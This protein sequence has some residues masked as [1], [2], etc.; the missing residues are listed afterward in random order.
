MNGFLEF[1]D[2]LRE[3]QS[4]F[5]L[6]IKELLSHMDMKKL[7]KNIAAMAIGIFLSRCGIMDTIYPFGQGYFICML[8]YSSYYKAA[9]LGCFIGWLSLFP[10]VPFSAMLVC[11]G[12]MGALT[13]ANSRFKVERSRLLKSAYLLF[14]LLGVLL[15]NMNGRFFAMVGIS[16]AVISVVSLFIYDKTAKA[17][18]VHKKRS[19]LTDDE[20]ICLVF[21]LCTLVIFTGG[22]K[23]GTLEVNIILAGL[24]TLTFGYIFGSTVGAATGVLCGLCVSLG[25][26]SVYTMGSMGV[27]GFFAGTAKG[28]GRIGSVIAYGAA[29]SLLTIYV[30][31]SSF[32]ILPIGCTLVSGLVLVLMPKKVMEQLKELLCNTLNRSREERYYVEKYNSLA[33]EK[34]DNL[35]G[36]FRTMAQMFCESSRPRNRPDAHIS[37]IIK[38][39]ADECCKE[40]VWHKKCW[41]EDF[42]ATYS[43]FER[44]TEDVM[45]AREPAK[46][47][48]RECINEIGVIGAIKR[49]EKNAREERRSLQRSNE[50]KDLLGKQFQGVAGLLMGMHG[51]IKNDVRFESDIE[52]NIRDE[53]TLFNVMVYD[54]CVM[55]VAGAYRC[56]VSVKGCGGSL[57]CRH[58]I[59]KTVSKFCGRPMVLC[60]TL[61]HGKKNQRCRLLYIAAKPLKVNTFMSQ[62]S[63]ESVCGDSYKVGFISDNRYM[64]CISDGM[65][66]GKSAHDESNA[67]IKLLSGFFKAGFDDSVV[68]ATVNK[69]LMLKSDTEI[70]TT[71]DLCMVDTVRSRAVFTKIGA[72]PSVLIKEEGERAVIKGDSLPLGI[73]EEVNEKSFEIDIE[74]G[75]ILV[76][77]TDG[78]YDA[79]TGKDADIE[80][81][82]G[83]IAGSNK[84]IRDITSAII[85]K[86]KEETDV[87]NRDDMTI[88]VS[89]FKKEKNCL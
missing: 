36:L 43:A 77:F 50:G 32:V 5:L 18:F 29:N 76:M 52:K 46:T 22:I 20:A 39:A 19:R 11:A 53:L 42:L 88:L 48:M 3:K 40:C 21:C 26:G 31:G 72:V 82:I 84:D 35:A 47:E 12:S 41:E 64:L 44:I 54:V 27:C 85:E 33:K 71:V 23:I 78:V 2:G 17:L 81:V 69:L 83:D 51:D 28:F 59:E 61:C 15:F 67:C 62:I 55:N 60:D 14:S 1:V 75:D 45:L 65:G 6:G 57:S 37:G 34:M 87:E 89:M 30:N 58:K 66:S 56:E 16:E 9:L 74:D 7:V 79:L 25:G 63:K 13:L 38:K 10:G 70:F 4:V 8:M 86:C 73:L 68:F 80:N 24:I 49:A